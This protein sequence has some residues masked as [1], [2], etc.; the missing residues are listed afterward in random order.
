[1]FCDTARQV[2][3]RWMYPCWTSRMAE[4]VLRSG[5]RERNG[6]SVDLVVAPDVQVD[7]LRIM[8]KFSG[9]ADL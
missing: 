1:M 3:K 7:V 8:T 9:M 5:D 2:V 4:Y 6:Y